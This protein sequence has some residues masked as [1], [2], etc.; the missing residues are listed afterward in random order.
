LITR[1]LLRYATVGVAHNLA[2][3]LLYLLATHWGGEPKL[4]MSVLFALGIAVSFVFN[5]RWAFEH[6]GPAASSLCRFFA[7]YLLGYVLNFLA[8]WIF[9]DQLGYAHQW[10]QAAATVSIAALSFLLNRYFVFSAPVTARNT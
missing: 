4:V 5:R 7:V 6:T 3:Y 8:L 2:G 10:V 9:H 1:Q